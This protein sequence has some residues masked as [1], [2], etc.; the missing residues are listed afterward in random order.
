M[1]G[2]NSNRHISLSTKPSLSSQ[3]SPTKPISHIASYLSLRNPCSQRVP[4]LSLR[5]PFSQSIPSLSPRSTTSLIVT[6][7]SHRASL[8]ELHTNSLSLSSQPN[9]SN[10][11]SHLKYPRNPF[12]LSL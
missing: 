2:G 6:T 8:H 11:G 1:S 7:I 9:L 4:S 12:P 10:R 3:P 5:K